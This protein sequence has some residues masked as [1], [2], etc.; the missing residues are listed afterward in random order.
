MKKKYVVALVSM[1]VLI[2]LVACGTKKEKV[3][4]DPYQDKQFLLGTYVQVKV[5]DEGKK[6]AIKPAM[7]LI[8]KLGDEMEVNDPGTSEIDKVNNAAGVKPVVIDKTMYRLVKKAYSFSAM[9]NGQFDLAIG[10]ITQLWHIGFDDARKPK[11][12]EIDTALKLVN[13]KDVIL[14]DKDHSVF[15]KKKGMQLDL[16]AIG[17]GF[18]TDE[19]ADLLK[20][21][22]VTTAI[23]DL[24][25]NVYVMGHSPRGATTPWTVG[26]QDPN[27]A[28]NTVVGYIPGVN[29]SF[30]TSGIYERYLKVD[31]ETYHH[32]MNPQTGYPFQNDIAGVTIVSD[33]SVDGDGW[34]TTIFAMGVQKGLAFIEQ[35][36]GVEAIFITRDNKVYKTSGV[37]NTF[38]LDPNSGYVLGDDATIQS[39]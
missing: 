4:R 38:Y 21:R 36:K 23:I 14:N 25:G 12:S 39:N 28:R 34:S 2:T 31:G 6:S 37:K 27:K 10:P 18:I 8:K 22:G 7:K 5:Y 19:V 17:K 16:G 30:V 15:L 11:Q 3:L 20:A 26:I 24:G 1:L 32:L 29:K 9:S 35:Q 13:Y 33:K